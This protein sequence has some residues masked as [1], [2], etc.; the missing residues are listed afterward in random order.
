MKFKFNWP[1]GFR[2]KDGNVDGQMDRR[3]TPES[4][5]YYWLNRESLAQV[6]V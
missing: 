2:G 5:V 1:S 6:S 3:Q 4:F